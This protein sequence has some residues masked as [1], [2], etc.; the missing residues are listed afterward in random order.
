[1]AQ[2]SLLE[3]F[4]DLHTSIVSFIPILIE[5]VERNINGEVAM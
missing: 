4:N 5:K 2:A 1:M 3:P